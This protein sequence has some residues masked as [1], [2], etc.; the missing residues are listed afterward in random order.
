MLALRTRGGEVFGAVLV[1]GFAKNQ[2]IFEPDREAKLFDAS[3]GKLF[4]WEHPAPDYVAMWT[5]TRISIGCDLEGKVALSLD[6]S[7]EQVHLEPCAVFANP[8]LAKN[9]DLIG[10]EVYSF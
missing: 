4:S 9:N 1:R 8:A 10:L 7:L 2:G 6:S 3:G 5:E